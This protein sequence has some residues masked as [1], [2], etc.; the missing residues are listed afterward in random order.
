[1]QTAGLELFGFFETM[2]NPEEKFPERIPDNYAGTTAVFKAPLVLDLPYSGVWNAADGFTSLL[3]V[4]LADGYSEVILS[5]G[6][7]NTLFHT[8]GDQ[9]EMVAIND[10][11]ASLVPCLATKP[12]PE[13]GGRIGHGLRV[14]S[15]DSHGF[16]CL[17][18]RDTIGDF[19]Y[20][21]QLGP[22]LPAALGW[23][24]T[25]E[26]RNIGNPTFAG[27]TRL[28][29]NGFFDNGGGLRTAFPEQSKDITGS[30]EVV[31]FNMDPAG[32]GALNAWITQFRVHIEDTDP[33]S[34]WVISLSNTSAQAIF[35]MI[36]PARS[37]CAFRIRDTPDINQLADTE[38]ERTTAL[39]GLCTYMGS[40]L[41][42]G[43]VISGAR[44]GMGLTPMN[45]PDGDVYG[46]LAQLPLYND[47]FALKVG[48]YSWWLP[49]SI[50]EYFYVPYRTPRSDFVGTTSLL[51]FAMHRDDPTQGVRLR[52][53]HC[54]EVI[55]RSRLYA[56]LPAPVNPT[57][58]MLVGLIK[59]LPAVT[60]NDKHPGILARA[61]RAIKNVVAS[62]ANWLKVIKGGAE[63]VGKAFS[64]TSVKEAAPMAYPDYTVITPSGNPRRRAKKKKKKPVR[65]VLGKR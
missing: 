1:L 22:Q 45:A 32:A 4:P 6:S 29:L 2:M 57:Y 62:P 3:P 51:C 38:S 24:F 59:T 41:Q 20:E 44:L 31:V 63:L 9:V 17:P 56:S 60:V 5:P 25:M 12:T 8:L 33:A 34:W 13:V 64:Q 14:A 18:K 19:W 21:L 39:S 55:T 16:A 30:H 61:L 49:D 26:V 36:L 11:D 7:V 65:Y 28:F 54:L 43:G 58:D 47:D 10:R 23:Q 40:H 35:P 53:Q 37:A 15:Q 48:C 50:Q 42:D 27:G 52:M 46:Y